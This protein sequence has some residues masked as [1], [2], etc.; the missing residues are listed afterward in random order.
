VGL[1]VALLP[2]AA[3][4][5]ARD[6][7]WGPRPYPIEVATAVAVCMGE[8]PN[9]GS[10]FGV[11]GS[12]DGA[13]IIAGQQPI[14]FV[15]RE[16]INPELTPWFVKRPGESMALVVLHAG[17]RTHLAVQACYESLFAS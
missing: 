12:V 13:Y 1:L 8:S 2:I 4:A 7:R 17:Q 3:W 14:V 10:A 5:Q 15:T 9:A 6:A 16:E 11:S